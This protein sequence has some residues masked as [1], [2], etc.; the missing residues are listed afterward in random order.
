MPRSAGPTAL[1]MDRLDE[2]VRTLDIDAVRNHLFLFLS[3]YLS[4]F[5]S[6]RINRLD[7]KQYRNDSRQNRPYCMN[8]KQKP[9]F[10]KYTKLD[11]VNRRLY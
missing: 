4:S 10:S 11:E 8:T 2:F 9:R 3:L 7:G 5:N 6:S 1:E